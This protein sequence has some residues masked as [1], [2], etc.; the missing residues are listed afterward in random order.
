[1]ITLFVA[2]PNFGLPDPSP[3]VTKADVLLKMSWVPYRTEIA[4]FGKAPKGKIPYI[5]DDGKLLGDSTFIRFHLEDKYGADFDKGLTASDRAT[6]WAFEKLAED[7]LYWAI[8]DARWTDKANFDKGPRVFFNAVSAPLR[9]LIVAMVKRSVRKNLF[10]HGMGRHAKPE[11][12]R[13]AARDLDAIA[14]FLS[15]KPWL[16][17]ES[18]C[19]ADAAVW[20]MVVGALCPQFATPVRTAA[21]RHANLTAYAK[22]GLQRWYPE[23][24]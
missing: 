23:Y 15:E 2:G 21:E 7:H 3:F 24:A 14:A 10:G 16:M 20:A 4:S 6:A 8:V 13:L 19:G 17:G 1:M 18:P 12:E 22:R 9:P 11:I 5:E